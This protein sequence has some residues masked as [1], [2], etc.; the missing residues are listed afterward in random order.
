MITQVNLQ[1][2]TADVSKAFFSDHRGEEGEKNIAYNKS[3]SMVYSA[4]MAQK[5][6]EMPVKQRIEEANSLNSYLLLIEIA[7]TDFIC[8]RTHRVYRMLEERGLLR[9][10]AKK[11]AKALFDTARDLQSRCNRYDLEFVGMFCREIYPSMLDG[12]RDGGGTI[13]LRLQSTFHAKFEPYVERAYF[14]TKNAYDKIKAKDSDLA[15]EIQMVGLLAHTGIEFYEMVCLR[16]D[17]MLEGFM[18]VRRMKSKHNE[19]MLCHA[20]ELGR[21]FG[22]DDSRLPK[23]EMEDAREFCRQFQKEL[24]GVDTTERINACFTILK[25]DF[26]EY[27]IA[28]L[29]IKMAQGGGVSVTDIRTLHRRLGRMC[30]VRKLLKE[31][32]AIPY[33]DDGATDAF[34]LMGEL[35]DSVPESALA[36][37]RTLSLEG[38]E[39]LP[40]EEPSDVVRCRKLRQEARKNAGKLSLAT[41]KELYKELKTKKAVSALLMEAGL[42]ESAKVFEKLTVKE[43]K[44]KL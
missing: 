39:I 4:M 18:N 28:V 44:A 31:I 19:K 26:I 29:R 9:H 34:D 40:V 17:R 16:V 32:S 37:Y 3:R 38:K 21:M 1:P 23:K 7:M 20:R 6:K 25:V 33:E 35:P 24:C 42:K 36:V 22:T 12:F 15:S 43:L 30:N 10:N 13:T 5:E 11:Q 14:A 41:F 8:Q 2:K 27:T